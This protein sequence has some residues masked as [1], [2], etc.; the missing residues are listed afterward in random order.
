MQQALKN[1]NSIQ[2]N[3]TTSTMI[4]VTVIRKNSAIARRKLAVIK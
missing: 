3:L 1:E 2:L 4:I